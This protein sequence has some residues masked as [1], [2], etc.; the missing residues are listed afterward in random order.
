MQNRT[1]KGKTT[2]MFSSVKKQKLI[3]Y[4][5]MMI[6]PISQIIIFYF[7]VNINSFLMAFQSMDYNLGGYIFTGFGNFIDAFTATNL[8][9]YFSN[10]LTVFAFEFLVGT[11]GSVFFS[12]YI[13]KKNIGHGF[14]KIM[15]YMPHIISTTVFVILYKFFVDNAIPSIYLQLYG[16]EIEGFLANPN[17]TKIAILLFCILN[18]FGT[19]VL[20]YSSAMS[21]ISESIIESAELDGVTPFKEL[22]F[23]VL[24]SVWAT[25]VTFAIVK[26]V[27]IFTN[28]MNL[29]T[30]YENLAEP[31]LSTIGYWMYCGAVS[32]DLAEYPMFSAMGMAL[33]GIAV[34]ITL[35]LRWLLN[36]FGPS[37]D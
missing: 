9:H 7:Y 23:I 30:F 27:S 31:H 5:L 12:Y 11:L 20:M 19:S 22:L 16:I 37:V 32:G 6:L 18:G 1:D 25:F 36:K 2:T 33:T 34:P 15:L 14:F 17:T 29:Y 26:F 24:P 21:S 3:F 35:L 13:Y 4:T 28:Q 8:N 10:S